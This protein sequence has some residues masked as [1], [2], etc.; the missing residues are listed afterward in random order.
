[1]SEPVK[2]VLVGGFDLGQLERNVLVMMTIL[3]LLCT[4]YTVVGGMLSVLVTDFLQ[5]IVM[6]AGLLAVTV[7]VLV[8]VGWGPLAATVA[9][10]HGAGEQRR[11]H[12]VAAAELAAERPV[13][14][15]GV[16]DDADVD[17]GAGGR[18]KRTPAVVLAEQTP[19]YGCSRRHQIIVPA[20]LMVNGEER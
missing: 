7:L 5:F 15:G 19:T 4:I 13:G 9:E 10:R 11:H 16:H 8:N 2:L 20:D 6:S 12:R 18:A 17:L 3:L 14:L 1:M